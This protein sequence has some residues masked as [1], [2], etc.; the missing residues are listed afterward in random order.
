VAVAAGKSM[1]FSIWDCLRCSL[2]RGHP[3][4]TACLEAKRERGRLN[5][6]LAFC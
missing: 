3:N 4:V 6:A 5:H 2:S 1:M